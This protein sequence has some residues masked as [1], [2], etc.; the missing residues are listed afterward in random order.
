[1]SDDIRDANQRFVIIGFPRSGTTLLSRILDAHPEISCPP[2]THLLTAAARFLSEQNRVEGP[3]IGVLSGVNFLGIEAEDVR[4]P[5]RDMVFGFH[6]RV[7]GDARVWVEKTGVDIFHL[8]TLEPLLVG[9][10]KF[11]LLL[12]NPLDVIASNMDLS[13]AMG[14]QLNDLRAL[15]RDHDSPH[16]G[17]AHAWV[18]R[19][20]AV[21][22]FAERNSADCFQ[23]NYEDFV[24]DP[25]MTLQ[26]LLQFMGVSDDAE[27]LVASA[28]AHTPRYGLGDFRINETAEI[29]SY[30]PN[31]WR[32]RLP[33][34]AISRV[35]PIVAPLMEQLGYKAPNAPKTPGREDA[36][37]QFLMAA[38]MKRDMARTEDKGT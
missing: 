29:R 8:E 24:T 10:T 27:K 18:N 21:A 12:R 17:L 33:R 38:Q 5:L 4:A 32:K 23:I 2:E 35:I 7:A 30:V 6:D 14:A 31:G 28:F 22:D 20:E 9:H 26:G 16:E 37:R 1:M 3:P 36:V 19:M 13:D 11:I 34:A 15:T 25:T